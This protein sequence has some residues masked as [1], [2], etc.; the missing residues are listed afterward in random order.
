VLITEAYREDILGN[1]F[2]YDRVNINATAGT[3]GYADGM[4]KFFYAN[5]FMIFDFVK[6]FTPVTD[7][8]IKN[9]QKIAKENNLKIEYI[10]KTKSFRKDD[11][12]AEI[13]KTRGTHEGMVHIFSQKETY[14]SYEPWH[15][16]TNH[17]THFKNT[18]TNSLVYYFYFID[19][20]LGLCFVKVPLRAPFKVMFYY[21]GHN[22]L[23]N[24]LVKKSI[25]FKKVDNAFLSIDD[26]NEAQRMCNKIRIPDL[27]QAL[28]ILVKRYCP[29]PEEWNLEFNFTISQIEYALD[30][31]F[32]NKDKLKYLYNNVVK[33]AMHTITPENIANFLGK[34]FSNLFE[35]ESG[36]RYNKRILGTRIKHQMGAV[37]VKMYDKFGQ[38]LR[39]ELTCHD[40]SKI[41]IFRDVN[42]K[43]GSV[44]KKVAP[45]KKS[46]YSLYPLMSAFKNIILR[47]LE[48][49]SS[50]DDPSDGM[51]NLKKATEDVFVN[52]KNFKGFNFFNKFDETILLAISDGRYCIRGLSNKDIRN[53]LISKSSNQVS[54]ILKRLRLHGLIKKIRKSYKYHLTSFGRKIISAGLKFKNMCLVPAL[55]MS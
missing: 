1:L 21:N 48:F 3:F 6:I 19:R 16:K 54:R 22:W 14:N 17:K 9:A 30:I 33:T 39:I 47:Y 40:V 44:E 26:F 23:E 5:N 45:A 50:F 53:Q 34:R 18:T 37:S 38:I 4:T 32:K 55:S 51:K 29:L 12:I 46:I 20:L 10:P 28:N 36:T 7:N 24:K 8:I 31:S 41:N 27:H 15:D 35:G 49:I 25:P 42:K 43:D 52:N 13:I 2:C 11:K